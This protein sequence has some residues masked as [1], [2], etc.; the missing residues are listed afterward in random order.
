MKDRLIMLG[1]S[2]TTAS[3]LYT[4]N[5]ISLSTEATGGSNKTTTF[6]GDVTFTDYLYPVK[7]VKTSGAP[8][9]TKIGKINDPSETSIKFDDVF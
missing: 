4:T 5:E 1:T 9:Y 6:S 8:E 2:T 3:G 7:S